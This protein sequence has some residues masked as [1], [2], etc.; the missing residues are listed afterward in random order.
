MFV[1][2]FYCAYFNEKL[3]GGPAHGHDMDTVTDSDLD[4]LGGY[5]KKKAQSIE[6][7]EILKIVIRLSSYKLSLENI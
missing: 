7:A 6:C 1:C 4:N 5:N 3:L 2:R